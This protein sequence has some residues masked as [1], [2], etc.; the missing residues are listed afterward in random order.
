MH[1][2]VYGDVLFLL[3]FSIDFLVLLLAGCFLHFPRKLFRLLPAAFLGG[4]YAV[5][6]LLPDWPIPL[7]L[8]VDLLVACLLCAVAY[9]PMGCFSFLKLV[10]M[11]YTISILLGGMLNALY[12]VLSDF[13]LT[14]GGVVT[15]EEKAKAFMLYAVI[16]GGLIFLL[17]RVFSH[18]SGLRSVVL[19]IKEGERSLQV[20]GLL[21]S[22]N[23]LRDPA[24]GKPV[25]LLL[26]KHADQIFPK[27]VKNAFAEGGAELPHEIKRRARLI[28]A[29]GMG[30]DRVMTGY[31]PSSLRIYTKE[32][33]GE[34][35]KIEAVIAIDEREDG[36]FAGCGA[37]V[38]QVLWK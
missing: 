14:A 38:P 13:F 12:G 35:R 32:H 4:V 24:S 21:D 19:E 16:G 27:G 26:S 36:D 1:T 8:T 5:L 2:V 9:A 34:A 17:G 7:A 18:R 23:F 28:L 31:I 3:N 10:S 6:A 22:G 15:N 37:I 11:F 33:P 29:H 30:G 25:I 20:D